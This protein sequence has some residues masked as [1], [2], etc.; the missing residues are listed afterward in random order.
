MV[1]A[2]VKPYPQSRLL[3]NGRGRPLLDPLDQCVKAGGGA[4]G[5]YELRRGAAQTRWLDSFA[6][7]TRPS[8]RSCGTAG[9]KDRPKWANKVREELTQPLR[10][11]QEICMAGVQAVRIGRA[12]GLLPSLCQAG[13]SLGLCIMKSTRTYLYSGENAALGRASG[14]KSWGAG[15]RQRPATAQSPAYRC[16]GSRRYFRKRREGR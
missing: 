12:E 15:Q 13:R 2:G 8:R 1:L 9:S 3:Q 7:S 11:G 5:L 10:C 6:A 14:S 4:A 16:P